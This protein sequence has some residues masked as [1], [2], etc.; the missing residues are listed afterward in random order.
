MGAVAAVAFGF[1]HR[2]VGDVDQAVDEL[3]RF[4]YSGLA[5]ISAVMSDGGDGNAAARQMPNCPST[6]ISQ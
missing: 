5:G 4:G 2:V 6:A 3:A 1:V